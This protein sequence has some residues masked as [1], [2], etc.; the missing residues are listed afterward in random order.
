MTDLWSMMGGCDSVSTVDALLASGCSLDEL[1]DD[2]HV[3]LELRSNTRVEDLTARITAHIF[4]RDNN[5]AARVSAGCADG[6]GRA[7]SAWK[8]LRRRRRHW[9]D[10]S[11]AGTSTVL[12]GVHGTGKLDRPYERGA[13]PT[14]CCRAAGL[15]RRRVLARRE[16]QCRY[17]GFL[18]FG[19]GTCA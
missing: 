16:V 8:S 17:T 14:V 2:L 13:C 11:R 3:L 10:S 6:C 1:F 19:A 18:G 12:W 5:Y 4:L 9:R 15:C 7:V